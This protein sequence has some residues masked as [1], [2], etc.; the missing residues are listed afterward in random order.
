[1]QNQKFASEIFSI[2]FGRFMLQRKRNSHNCAEGFQNSAGSTASTLL[3]SALDP[4]TGSAWR[5]E[6]P[7]KELVSVAGS[8]RNS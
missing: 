5:G 3:V 6:L 7:D 8:G 4:A 2:N 1:M